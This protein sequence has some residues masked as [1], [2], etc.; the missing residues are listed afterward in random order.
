MDITSVAIFNFLF[1]IYISIYSLYRINKLEI[2]I[3]FI[4]NAI[5]NPNLKKQIK[6]EEIWK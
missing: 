4:M 2:K 1:L 5:I 6:E 3:D